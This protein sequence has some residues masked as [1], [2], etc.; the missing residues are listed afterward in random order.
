MAKN[1]LERLYWVPS[2]LLASVSQTALGQTDSLPI[3]LDTVDMISIDIIEY[4]VGQKS[5][6][7]LTRLKIK[8]LAGW[9][10]LEAPGENWLPG[11]SQQY[12]LPVPPACS[13]FLIAQALLPWAPGLPLLIQSP[14]A[15]LL[16]EHL[17][18]HLGL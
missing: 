6:M 13:P 16:K 2:T 12:G 18:L 9:V 5:K 1:Y 8:V 15:S 10:L 14:S 4:S 3:S 7:S 17:S 11:L